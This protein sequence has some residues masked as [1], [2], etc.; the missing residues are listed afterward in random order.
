MKWGDRGGIRSY[1]GSKWIVESCG[2]WW[3]EDGRYCGRHVRVE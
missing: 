2:E 3:T 1:M